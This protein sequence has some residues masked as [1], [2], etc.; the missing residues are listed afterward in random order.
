M[1]EIRLSTQAIQFLTGPPAS[2]ENPRPS[3]QYSGQLATP[4]DGQVTPLKSVHIYT[5]GH[6]RKVSCEGLV[7]GVD[8]NPILWRLMA[9]IVVGYRVLAV[10]NAEVIDL[11]VGTVLWGSCN[12]A[13][14]LTEWLLLPLPLSTTR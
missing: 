9:G 1:A 14:I 7:G 5:K 11:V 2:D 10:D 13:L 12:G 8:S 3:S 4:N 6:A